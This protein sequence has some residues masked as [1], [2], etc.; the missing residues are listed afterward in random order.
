MA[1]KLKAEGVKS[2]VWDCFL[3]TPR[4][5]LAGCWIEMKTGRNGLTTDQKVWAHLM[6]AAGYRCEDVCY[7]WTAAARAICGYLGV[8]AEDYGIG[9]T[10]RVVVG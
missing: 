6:R 2:G 4:G 7:D 8:S 1:G 9:A 5:G 3:A 10:A